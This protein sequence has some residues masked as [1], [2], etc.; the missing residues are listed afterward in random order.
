M[1]SAMTL[2]PHPD[3]K[4]SGP[5]VLLF[6]ILMAHGFIG[7]ALVSERTG[8]L[9]AALYLLGWL[10]TLYVLSQGIDALRRGPPKP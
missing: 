2:Y 6:L 3:A 5:Y 8:Y 10:V 7:V 9:L 1:L 4:G